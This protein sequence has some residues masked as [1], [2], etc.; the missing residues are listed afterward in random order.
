MT[1]HERRDV[2][3]PSAADEIAFPMFGHRSEGGGGAGGDGNLCL[4]N[5]K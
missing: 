1:F 5:S 3:V 2:T 4:S